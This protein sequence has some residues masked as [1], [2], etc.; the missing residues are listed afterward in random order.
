MVEL[1]GDLGYNVSAF[2]ALL[3]EEWSV[4]RFKNSKMKGE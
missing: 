2:Q 4:K 1:K 3:P